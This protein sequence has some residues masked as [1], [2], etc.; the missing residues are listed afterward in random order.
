MRSLAVEV[1]EA[2]HERLVG[3]GGTC[4]LL[5]SRVQVI[6]QALIGVKVFGGCGSSR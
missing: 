3:G 6:L 4:I 2:M 5:C 1:N